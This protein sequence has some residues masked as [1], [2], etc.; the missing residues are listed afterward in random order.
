MAQGPYLLQY[1]PEH[2]DLGL[3]DG[4]RLFSSVRQLCIAPLITPC[5]SLLYERTL[6]FQSCI[7]FESEQ[8]HLTSRLRIITHIS[9][10]HSPFQCLLR[11]RQCTPE[12]NEEGDHFPKLIG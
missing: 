4:V 1:S 7:R 9:S 6:L 2:G 5:A 3:D 11:D 12:Q 8:D 10:R